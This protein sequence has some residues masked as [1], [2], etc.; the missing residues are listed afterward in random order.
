MFV[1]QFAVAMPKHEFCWPG[2]THTSSSSNQYPQTAARVSHFSAKILKHYALISTLFQSAWLI[3]AQAI[4]II[5][6][7]LS[8]QYHYTYNYGKF[9]SELSVPTSLPRLLTRWTLS[10]GTFQRTIELFNHTVS[11]SAVL[12]SPCRRIESTLQRTR[13]KTVRSGMVNGT[14]FSTSS[15]C[16]R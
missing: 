11:F 16:Y 14:I 4:A 5:P 2:R 7:S 9:A 15:Y 1:E 8:Y 6:C 10:Q 3:V 12:S 13:R